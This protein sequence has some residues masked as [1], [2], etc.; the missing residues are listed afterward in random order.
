MN[1]ATFLISLAGAIGS[2]LIAGVFFAF[3]TFIMPALARTTGPHGAEAM[4]HINRTVLN[5]WFLSVFMGTALLC[6]LIVGL[7]F[8][9][10]G[11]GRTWLAVAG[12]GLYLIGTFGVTVAFN[13]PMNEALASMP[14][15][16]PTTDSYWQHYLLRWTQWNTLRTLAATA[17]CLLLILALMR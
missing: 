13:V 16:E 7:S 17:A 12:A 4:Q 1:N 8:A 11:S 15:G 5:G 9:S 14:L 10:D 3:S 6:L 2:G